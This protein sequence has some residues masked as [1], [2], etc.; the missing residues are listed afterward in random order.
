MFF[1]IRPFFMPNL[2]LTARPFSQ[3]NP[4]DPEAIAPSIPED[5]PN[6]P[7][8][9]EKGDTRE[10]GKKLSAKIYKKIAVMTGSG[11]SVKAGIHDFRTPTTGLYAQIEDPDLPFPEAIF[12]LNYFKLDPEPFYRISPNLITTNKI[13][14]LTH[15]FLKL[16]EDQGILLMCYTQNIDSLEKKAGLSSKKLVQAHGNVD[17]SHCTSCKKDY[18]IS[19]LRQHMLSKQ[20]AFCE[21]GGTIKPDIVFF[22]EKLPQEFH[23]KSEL[24]LYADLLLIIGT[25]L[26]A[27][28]FASLAQMVSPNTPRIV[29]NKGGYNA[30]A[31]NG[32]KF[33][34][35]MKRD[36]F[37]DGDCDEII[38][39]IVKDTQW[40]D[41]LKKLVERKN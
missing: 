40:D 14:T 7:I 27:Y 21:C 3:R 5:Q 28:P 22:G 2:L 8:Y 12:D 18:P 38:S 4:F 35:E 24:I 23:S 25:S 39:D 10:I 31:Q 17:H 11:I 30:F 19:E 29:I 9:F 34:S 13:P 20:P 15:Y 6:D 36:I 33:D 16:L 32:F 26:T 1:R 37:F 41:S